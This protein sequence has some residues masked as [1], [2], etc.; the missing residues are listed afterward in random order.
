MQRAHSGSHLHEAHGTA[1]RARADRPE[2]DAPRNLWSTLFVLALAALSV[3]SVFRS[4]NVSGAP[5]E[6]AAILMRYSEHLA[7]GA[8]IVWNIGEHPVDGP[9]IFF[10]W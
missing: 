7:S 8:G 3:S 10:S 4:L 1:M 5:S 2:D 6:D 9:R